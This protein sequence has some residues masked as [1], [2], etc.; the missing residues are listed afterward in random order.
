MAFMGV[1]ISWLMLERM[2]FFVFELSSAAVFLYPVCDELDKLKNDEDKNTSAEENTGND[3][4]RFPEYADSKI[5]KQE[6]Y[7][8]DDRDVQVSP[9]LSP[10]LFLLEMAGIL[11]IAVYVVYHQST[12]EIYHSVYQPIHNCHP[13][14]EAVCCYSVI[15]VSSIKRVGLTIPGKILFLRNIIIIVIFL[16]E[17]N[18]L[19]WT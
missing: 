18:Y 6:K 1:R 10:V 16:P 8:Q 9:F 15:L 17:L 13:P 2:A 4:I 19:T 5:T 3:Q 12:A 7:Q 14:F 11:N